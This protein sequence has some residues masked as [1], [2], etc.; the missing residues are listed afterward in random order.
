[1]APLSAGD[2]CSA[3][4]ARAHTIAR[5]DNGLH[6][7]ELVRSQQERFCKFYSR[8]FAS[9]QV[10]EFKSNCADPDMSCEKSFHQ[11]IRG[12]MK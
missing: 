5:K 3:A 8:S 10:T 9:Q 2:L 11:S 7:S 6:V 12:Q 1:L 4:P